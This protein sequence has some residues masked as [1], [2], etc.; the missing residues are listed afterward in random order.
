MTYK[1][2]REY[3]GEW[4]KDLMHGRGKFKWPSGTIFEGE[5]F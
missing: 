1:D 5:Y 4:Q 3:Q 2:G